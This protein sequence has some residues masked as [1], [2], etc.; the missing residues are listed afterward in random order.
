MCK[1]IVP[2]TTYSTTNVAGFSYP[3]GNLLGFANVSGNYITEKI[4][5]KLS[6]R[7]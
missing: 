3:S 5:L 7:I 4:I 1:R 6:V 2:H